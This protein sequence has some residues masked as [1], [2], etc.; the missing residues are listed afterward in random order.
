MNRERYQQLLDSLLDGE[1]SPAE[2]DEL[3]AG[4]R[5]NPEHQEELRHQLILWDVWSQHAAAERSVE[6][7]VEAWKTRVRAEAGSEQFSQSVLDRIS[8]PMAAFKVRIPFWKRWR[9]AQV[10]FALLALTFFAMAGW[11]TQQQI[12]RAR[13]PQ[14]NAG[15]LAQF[16]TNRVVTVSGEGVCIRCVLNETNHP[17]PAI[18]LK[19][20]GA[21]RIVYLDFPR[22]SEALHQFFT[23]GTTVKAKGRLRDDHGRLVMQTQS[24]EADGAEYR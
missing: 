6:S 17:G 19:Q 7:F 11:W 14:G 15:F 5:E 22:Y 12:S 1:L 16:G 2:A 21:T 20:D 13:I 8:K 24:I 23:G 9:P 18:R 3:L 10:G 4:L